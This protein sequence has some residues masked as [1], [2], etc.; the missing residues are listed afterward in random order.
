[1]GEPWGSPTSLAQPVAEQRHD[2]VGIRI[3][4]EHR[5]RE[6]ELAVHVHVE[7]PVG[8]R[9][10]LDAGDHVLPCLEEPRRQTGGVGQRPSG[11]AVLDADVVGVGHRLHPGTSAIAGA[12]TDIYGGKLT[13][14]EGPPGRAE[15]RTE[16][17][18]WVV[19]CGLDR[20]A[21][22]RAAASGRL[23]AIRAVAGAGAVVASHPAEPAAP[24]R[25]PPITVTIARGGLAVRGG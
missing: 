11:N 18:F 7:D 23:P 12:A 19:D 22:T 4:P 8:A 24:R 5:L 14:A 21:A 3:P 6:D 10:D 9:H 2:F 1:V 17:A 20:I 16:A 25:R 15:G 13:T